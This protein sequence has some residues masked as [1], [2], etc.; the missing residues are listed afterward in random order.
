MTRRVREKTILTDEPIAII[1]VGCRFPEEINDAETFWKFLS[2]G[3]DAI[4]EIPSDRWNV[5]KFY[6]EQPG[7]Q[8]KYYSRHGGFI[9][10]IHAFDAGFFGISPREAKQMDP[11]QKILLEVAWQAIEDA[12]LIVDRKK[13]INAGI[14]VGI[15]NQDYGKVCQNLWELEKL[16]THHATGI[17]FC[18]AANRISYVLNLVGPSFALDTACSSSLVAVHLACSSLRNGECEFALAGGA[19]VILNPETYVSFCNLSMLSPDG[20]CYAFD[21]RANGFVRSEGAGLVVLMPL[22]KAVREGHE[23][24]AVIRETGI[25]QDGN[26]SGITVPNRLAQEKLMRQVYRDSG[27]D[28][29]QV[30]FIEAHGTGTAIGDPVEAKAL[31]KI[32]GSKRPPNRPSY[33]G[34]V[35]TNIGHLESAAG[36]AGLIKAALVLKHKKIPQNLHY[37]KPNPKINFR[38]IHLK[39]PEALID[40]PMDYPRYA[41]VNSFGFG[42]TNAHIVLSPA[43]EKNELESRSVKI[44]ERRTEI[45]CLSAH[46]RDSLRAYAGR[47]H[48]SLKNGLWKK[49][50]TLNDI[51]GRSWKNRVHQDDRLC[52]TIDSRTELKERLTTFQRGETATGM[53]SGQILPRNKRKIVFVFSGQGPQWWAMGRE[54]LA[55]EPVF[56][57]TIMR[58]HELLSPY[59]EWSLLEELQA[60]EKSSRLHITSIAQPA[61]IA[62]QVALI[63]LWKTWGIKPDAVVGHSVGEVTAAYAAG[64]LTLKDALWVIYQR[65]RCMEKS[66]LLAGKMLAVSLS[67][68]DIQP[69]VKGYEG[70]VHVGAINSPESVT[71]SGDSGPIEEIGRKLASDNI[72]SRSLKTGYAFH[73]HHMEGLRSELMDSLKGLQIQAPKL[74]IYSTVRGGLAE[75]KDFLPRYWWKNVREQVKF[76]HAIDELIREKYGIFIELSPHPVLLSAITENLIQHEHQAVV[77]PSL[78]RNQA[79]QFTMLSSLGRFHTSGVTVNW[80]ALY[81]HPSYSARFPIYAWARD[82]SWQQSEQMKD[83]LFGSK[84]HPLLGTRLLDPSISWKTQINDV[85][86]PFLRDHKIH[87]HVLLPSTV[88]IELALTLAKEHMKYKF[89][90]LTNINLVKAAF[91]PE[92]KNLKLKTSYD[93][94]ELSFKIHSQE[95]NDQNAWNLNVY[96]T[97]LPPQKTKRKSVSPDEIR[98]RFRERWNQEQCYDKFNNVGIDYGLSFRGIT[99]LHLGEKEALAEIS[100]PE[101]VKGDLKEYQFHPVVMDMCLQAIRGIIYKEITWIP[102]YFRRIQ[103]YKAPAV[104]MWSYVHDVKIG[105]ENLEASITILDNKGGVIAEIQGILLRGFEAPDSKKS[106]HIDDMF[107]DYEWIHDPILNASKIQHPIKALQWQGT[108]LIF[109]DD[110]NKATLLARRLIDKGLDCISVRR[111]QCF[112]QVDEH[113]FIVLPTSR[114]DIRKLIAAVNKK[115]APKLKGLI[116]FWDLDVPR[117]ESLTTAS[118][119]EN[120]RTMILNNLFLLQESVL[121]EANIVPRIFLITRGAQS[122]GKDLDPVSPL[123]AS[124]WG[125]GRVIVNEHPRFRCT[126]VDLDPQLKTEKLKLKEIDLLLDEIIGENTEDELAFRNNERFIHRLRKS[127]LLTAFPQLK[128]DKKRNIRIS[129]WRLENQ[130][131]WITCF[132]VSLSAFRLMTKKSKSK[133]IRQGSISVML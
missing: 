30:S 13:S 131:C 63:E 111:G 46:D 107:Y 49:G 15:S 62:L 92:Y 85:M 8:G 47:C 41:A 57:Q 105:K 65:G 133:C 3:K 100:I 1:G 101:S 20:R 64:V 50:G 43:P 78:R 11:H 32:I 130:A 39:V 129:G 113:N 95:E 108:W 6:A 70:K 96:G 19:N 56:R 21:A 119:R 24:Y 23:I 86:I 132:C 48:D 58:C 84:E 66:G 126:L 25:N 115:D 74:P 67:Q 93:L 16:K 123:Q 116:H 103:L 102:I 53:S 69:Y 73:S 14:F 42:G 5:D 54:L 72:F 59:S 2:E 79:E 106:F 110:E 44:K 109:H 122:V 76:A 4:T 9:R 94:E 60:N 91:V 33:L 27:I 51:C 61:I 28:P 80:K 128:T 17:S 99:T 124:V 38:K 82:C 75:A 114:S 81:T 37:T 36:I 34:S 89:P 35:K 90:V 97:I 121:H 88:Y 118:F 120:L 127:V 125:L 18:I 87:G 45:F 77:L 104:H 55:S 112:K 52:V 68:M 98:K 29:G 10:E 31:G 7:I 26:T 71:L 40:W 117:L 22:S 83:F 12:G